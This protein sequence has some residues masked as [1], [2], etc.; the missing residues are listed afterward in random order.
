M[1]NLTSSFNNAQVIANFVKCAK[2]LGRRRRRINRISIL[3]DKPKVIKYFFAI[4][5]YSRLGGSLEARRDPPRN[6]TNLQMFWKLLETY[7]KF[8]ETY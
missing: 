4:L 8:L 6:F 1:Q 5:L 2:L 7:R 3:L